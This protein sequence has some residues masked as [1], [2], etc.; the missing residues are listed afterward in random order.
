MDI[1]QKVNHLSALVRL[2]SI[3]YLVKEDRIKCG[4]LPFSEDELTIFKRL[5]FRLPCNTRKL[6]ALFNDAHDMQ[7][8]RGMFPHPATI[9]EMEW[10]LKN[11]YVGMYQ[12][13]KFSW[14]PDPEDSDLKKL[15]AFKTLDALYKK[16]K[17]AL[18]PIDKTAITDE[19][20]AIINNL[21]I[22]LTKESA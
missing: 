22:S 20:T 13:C 12:K 1:Q 17:K 15:P 3:E 4:A 10:C 5:A 9:I 19:A 21:A 18:S 7:K 16:I 14:M 11:R 8:E 2:E 6:R